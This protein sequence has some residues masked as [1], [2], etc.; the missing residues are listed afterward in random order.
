MKKTVKKKVAAK[1]KVAVKKAVAKK[2]VVTKKAVAKKKVATKKKAA[3]KKSV[4][5]KKV[6]TKRAVVKKKAAAAPTVKPLVKAKKA[7][8]KTELLATLVDRSGV[9]KKDVAA[10][11]DGLSDVIEAHVKKGAIGTFNLPG[12]LKVKTIRKP[13]TKARKGINPFNGEE[14]IFKAKPARTVVK[15]LPLKKLKDMVV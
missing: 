6:A 13:A 15:V 14:T 7:Y 3:P 1:K 10:V 11:L 12:L 9:A 4:A 2:K 8:T 5:K